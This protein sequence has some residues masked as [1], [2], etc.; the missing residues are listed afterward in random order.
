ML[1]IPSTTVGRH[2]PI[3]DNRY[4]Q[5]ETWNFAVLPRGVVLHSL[6]Y[7]VSYAVASSETSTIF[8]TKPNMVGT[9]SGRWWF[10]EFHGHHIFKNLINWLLIYSITCLVINSV[11]PCLWK[12]REIFANPGSTSALVKCE[13]PLFAKGDTRSMPSSEHSQRR[14]NSW[15]ACVTIHTR[16][17]YNCYLSSLGSVL[18]QQQTIAWR[19]LPS[20]AYFLSQFQFSS[21]VFSFTQ[22]RLRRIFLTSTVLVRMWPKVN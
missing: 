13:L 1:T 14:G 9:N 6:Y 15:S 17:F 3:F 20:W 16:G 19:F 18:N 22:K 10:C 8:K 11:Y 2:L 5:L 21:S 7:R 12:Y 4:G